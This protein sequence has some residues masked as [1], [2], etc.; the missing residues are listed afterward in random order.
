MLRCAE[1]IPVAAL[2]AAPMLCCVIS[3]TEPDSSNTSERTTG[4]RA[5]KTQ[6]RSPDEDSL[7]RVCLSYLSQ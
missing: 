2:T 7:F 3:S 6:A 1:T 4:S 5:R